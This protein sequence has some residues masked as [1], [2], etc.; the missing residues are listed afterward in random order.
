MNDYSQQYKNISSNCIQTQEIAQQDT[1]TNDGYSE[2]LGTRGVND[3]KE[4]PVKRTAF[5]KIRYV[6]K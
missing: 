5:S 4:Y 3:N 6:Q 2:N 1:N